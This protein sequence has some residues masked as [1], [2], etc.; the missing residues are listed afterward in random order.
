M[1]GSAGGADGLGAD[2]F[3]VFATDSSDFA[4]GELHTPRYVVRRAD[5]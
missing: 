3:A 5:G 1:I 2:G 4:R